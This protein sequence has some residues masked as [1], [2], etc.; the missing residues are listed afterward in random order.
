MNAEDKTAIVR[1]CGLSKEFFQRRPLTRTKIT[2]Q[3]L[4]DVN[5]TV[6]RGTTL[7]IVGESGAGKSTLIRCLSLIEKPTAGQI[8][9]NDTDLLKLRGKRLF[10][11]RRRI[12][13]V[14]Q[15]PASALNPSMTAQEIIEEPLVIQKIGIRSERRE[16]ALKLMEQV[17]LPEKC[18]NK[19]PFEFSGGQ[20][21]RLAIA[22][23][24]AL[25]PNLLILDEALSNLDLANQDMILRLLS[26]L[27]AA[28]S[29][30][31]IHVSHDLRLMEGI[32]DEVAVMQNGRI[33]EQKDTNELFLHPDQPYTQEL[34][35]AAPLLESIVQARLAWDCR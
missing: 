33:V 35:E 28:R 10:A 15:D 34:L 18:A 11:M 14:F 20:R 25:E 16:L 19:L 21:Q 5:L 23:A 12:Q 29:L 6:R 1:V 7:A 22:R 17:G 3:A 31:Y 8:W 30:T 9:W 26:D 32:A 13:V 2:I 24:L 4:I 27:Q